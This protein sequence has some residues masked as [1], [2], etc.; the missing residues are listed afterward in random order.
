VKNVDFGFAF[1]LR[2]YLKEHDW[3]V[4]EI[5]EILLV[6]NYGTQWAF[7]LVAAY[8]PSTQE[9]DDYILALHHALNE[10]IDAPA[11]R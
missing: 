4:D 10:A 2:K 6:G 1:A 3:P 11:T 5:T 7:Q 8:Q 9:V